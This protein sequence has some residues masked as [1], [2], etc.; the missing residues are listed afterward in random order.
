MK[1]YSTLL[2]FLVLICANLAHAERLAISA[3]VANVRSGPGTKYDIIWKVEKYHPLFIINKANEWYRF[4]DFEGDK[5]WVHKSLV[6]KIKTIITKNEISMWISLRS[7]QAGMHT[8]RCC[9]LWP[10]SRT[11]YYLQVWGYIHFRHQNLLI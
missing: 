9:N 4:E 11:T 3:T 10:C 7:S 8:T 5:G 1:V 2:V 6:G